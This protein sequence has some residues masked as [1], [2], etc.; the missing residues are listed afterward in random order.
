[1]RCSLCNVYG[2]H[3]RARLVEDLDVADLSSGDVKEAT[4]MATTVLFQAEPRKQV[5][6]KEPQKGVPISKERKKAS[7]KKSKKAKSWKKPSSQKGRQPGR[8]KS[9]TQQRIPT[10]PP[11]RVPANFL[12]SGGLWH[13]VD[14]ED[15]STSTREFARNMSK[16]SDPRLAWMERTLSKGVGYQVRKFG[17]NRQYVAPYTTTKVSDANPQK[18]RYTD[19][20]CIDVTRVILRDAP[21]DYI[22]ANYIVALTGRKFICTQRKE[23]NVQRIIQHL[24]ATLLLLVKQKSSRQSSSSRVDWATQYQYVTSSMELAASS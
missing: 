2:Q 22:N 19:I 10:V 24:S 14:L 18:N 12:D 7:V 17:A 1:M 8:S 5:S 3:E 23:V 15:D 9:L 21:P 6:A 13:V 20:K 4:P 11:S 16:C